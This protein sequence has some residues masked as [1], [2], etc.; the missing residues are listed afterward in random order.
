MEWIRNRTA[1]IEI[2]E[3]DLTSILAATSAK[4]ELATVYGRPIRAWVT[5]NSGKLSHACRWHES[6]K[7]RSG[8]GIGWQ[9]FVV[10]HNFKRFKCTPNFPGY[11]FSFFIP[12]YN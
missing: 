11:K 4:N 5:S 8:C 3:G 1:R 9:I 2:I 7:P 10:A 6:A 12:P